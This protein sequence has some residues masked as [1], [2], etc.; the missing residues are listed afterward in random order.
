M[1][2]SISSDYKTI[3]TIYCQK[4]FHDSDDRNNIHMVMYTVNIYNRK[5]TQIIVKQ[6]NF[7]FNL[8]HC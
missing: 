1:F 8:Q 4:T 2:S 3:D 5:K 6:I 7:S